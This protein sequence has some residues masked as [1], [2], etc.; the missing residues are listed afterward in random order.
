MRRVAVRIFHPEAAHGAGPFE[1]QLAAAR[2]VVARRHDAAFRRAGANN[3]AIEAG[4]PDGRSFGDRIREVVARERPAG[5]VVLGSGALALAT[6]R[7]LRAFVEAAGSAD[8]VALANNRYSADAIAV[9]CAESLLQVPDLPSDN[10]LP[11]WL[12]EVGGYDVRD[13][14]GRWRLGV[15]LDSPL[16]VALIGA[17]SPSFEFVREQLAAV[18]AVATDRRAE[19]VVAGRTS[20]TTMRWLETHV[21]A[22]VRLLA[23]ERGL[24]ASSSLALRGGVPAASSRR[25]RSIIG[26]VLDRDGPDAL[27]AVVE[28]LG[29]AAVIDTRVLIA[30][31]FGANESVWPSA[32]DRFGSD[33][34]LPDGIRD[35]W[36]RALT[37]AAREARIPIV[38]GGHTLV[39]PGLRLALRRADTR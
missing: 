9:A 28:E 31:R 27:G 16:D 22:R 15:D 25:P 12:A 11:R 8:R 24:R 10:A 18:R 6:T 30:H 19:I 33:L 4:P 5:I 35:R 39:G 38:L 20:A 23:E 21:P 32:E 1:Q 36:L 34:L 14:S 29:E 13:L 26:I 3:V 37:V 7:D 2:L 17:D